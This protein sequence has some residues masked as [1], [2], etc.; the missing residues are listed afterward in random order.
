MY[1]SL[2]NSLATFQTMMN[3]IFKGHIDKGYVIIYMDDIL[4]FTQTI[5]HRRE[6]VSCVLN[7][8]QRYQLYLK[9]EKC[10]FE[11]SRVEYLSLILSERCVEMDLVKITGVKEWPTPKNVTEVQSFVSSINFYRPFIPDFS[12]MA[13]PL[14]QLT[15]KGEPWHWS[16]TEEDAFCELK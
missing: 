13:K 1:F 9:A 7:T 10:S 8:L 5:K 14:H 6:V 12:H 4:I 3:D 15:K 11:C 16:G 2:T